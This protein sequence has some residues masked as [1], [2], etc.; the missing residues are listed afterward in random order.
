MPS[1]ASIP[2]AEV[3][4]AGRPSSSSSSLPPPSRGSALGALRTLTAESSDLG[5]PTL[6]TADL[7]TLMSR[8]RD[9]L[10]RGVVVLS[11]LQRQD[12]RDDELDLDTVD[13]LFSDNEPARSSRPR[14]SDLCFAGLMEIKGSLRE[15]GEAREHDTQHAAIE[16]AGRKLRRALRAVLAL[17]AEGTSIPPLPAATNEEVESALAVR[18]IYAKFRRGLRR[19]DGNTPESVLRAVQY[20]AG[21]IAALV[22]SPE[23]A[24]LRASDRAMLRGLRDRAFAWARGSRG[25][26]DGLSVLEDIHTSAN[27]LR[28]INQRQEL[29]VHD[30]DALARLP[31]APTN[32]KLILLM[33]LEGLDDGLD[34]L[35]E[36]MRT[37]ENVEELWR[38][39]ARRIGD[40]R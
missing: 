24:S 32:E 25:V 28:G 39:V 14:V 31:N 8:A 6:D 11:E 9:L 10:E 40:L 37:G 23:Y 7:D 30:W 38:L 4:A 13:D 1:S 33:R 17:A 21:A 18:R 34:Q 19:A 22:G 26:A 16:S 15:L 20:A 36:R 27:L 2:R 29:R 3:S 12:T 5:Q 35:I